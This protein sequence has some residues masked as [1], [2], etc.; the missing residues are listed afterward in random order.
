LPST[1]GW[2][3]AATRASEVSDRFPLEEAHAAI[4]DAESVVNAVEGW[5]A[6]RNV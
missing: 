3:V 2:S 6:E 4:R 1:S 5:L